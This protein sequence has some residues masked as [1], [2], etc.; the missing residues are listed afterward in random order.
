MENQKELIE[1]LEREKEEYKR[2]YEEA[3]KEIET[4]KK[5]NSRGAGRKQRFDYRDKELIRMYR[6]QGQTIEELAKSFNCSNGLI[7]KI[8][9]EEG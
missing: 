7:H 2:L 8:I 3:L 9:K 6:I 5:K 4:L 1:R